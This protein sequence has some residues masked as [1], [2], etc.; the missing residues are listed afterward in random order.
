MPNHFTHTLLECLLQCWPAVLQMPDKHISY[1][2]LDTLAFSCFCRPVAFQT[3]LIFLLML[4]VSVFWLCSNCLTI[5][6]TLILLTSVLAGLCCCEL[7]KRQAYEYFTST[8]FLTSVWVSCVPNRL[9]S[10]LQTTK[11]LFTCSLT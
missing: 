1:L 8:H 10:M 11:L 6:I 9:Q 5:S 4:P 3:F 2:L 7:W